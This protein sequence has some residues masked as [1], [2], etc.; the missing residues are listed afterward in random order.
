MTT[1]KYIIFDLDGLLIDSETLYQKASYELCSRFGKRPGPEL[2]QRAIGRKLAESM[3]IYVEM[4]DLPVTPQ[5]LLVMMK[6][7]MKQEIRNNLQM[8]PGAMDILKHFFNNY[9]LALATGSSQDL[10]KVVFERTKIN[11]FFDVIQSSD[12]VQN[13]KPDPEVFLKTM[14]KLR[15]RPGECIILE[16]A[17]NGVVA[18][19]NAGAYVIA[20]PNKYTAGYDFSKADIILP[21][22]NAAIQHMEN[23]LL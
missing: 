9:P 8:M 19:H 15:A 16:D 20:V 10:L 22:L 17:E 14:H 13:G 11:H 21:D 7:R 3:A 1:K 4:M 12:E 5:E 6:D 23:K 2:F 18:A